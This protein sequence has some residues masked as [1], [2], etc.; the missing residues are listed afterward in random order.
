LKNKMNGKKVKKKVKIL[1]GKK[2]I[3]EKK[4]KKI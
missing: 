2:R 4:K 1:R 3:G